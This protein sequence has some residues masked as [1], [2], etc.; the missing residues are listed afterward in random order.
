V[1]PAYLLT[2][3]FHKQ[4]FWSSTPDN[5]GPSAVGIPKRCLSLFR[6]GFPAPI[7]YELPADQFLKT[8]GNRRKLKISTKF[9]ARKREKD[10]SMLDFH[11]CARCRAFIVTGQIIDSTG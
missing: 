1:T 5:A 10:A 11:K 9:S 8:S 4:V 6:R 2:H 3:K 7:I